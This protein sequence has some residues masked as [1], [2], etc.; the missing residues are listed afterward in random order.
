[1]AD[2]RHPLAVA[3]L[4]AA[5]C[6]VPRR[7][8]LLDVVPAVSSQALVVREGVAAPRAVVQAWERD[9]SGWRR[10]FEPMAAVVGRSG[11]VAA[12]SK[13]EGDGGTPAGVHRIGHAFGYAV[14]VPTRL[15]YRQATA[16]DWWIDDPNSPSYNR[17]VTTK[18]E[19][20]AEPMRRDDGQYELGAVLEWNTAPVVSG[21]GSA[22][23][24][25][26]WK[27]PETATAGCIALSRDDVAS[28]LGWLDRARQPVIVVV[29][30]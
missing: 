9:G 5:A 16:S 14:Q 15:A 19:V 26:V 17:W 13:R 6:S 30:P 25:H 28:L 3:V 24:L 1:M 7:D 2:P 20:S 29:A 10:A 21:R 8:A 4:C 23:F 12:D 11:I 27:G 18:P 22:I